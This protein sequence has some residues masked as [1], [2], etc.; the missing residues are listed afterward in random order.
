[1]FTR[2][3][4]ESVNLVVNSWG[5]S[6]LQADD[7]VVLTEMEHHSNWCRGSCWQNKS[8]ST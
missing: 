1:V 3:T 5:R 4:T 6:K 2:N 7:L 8:F